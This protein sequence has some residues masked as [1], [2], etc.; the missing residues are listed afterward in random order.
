MTQPTDAETRMAEEEWAKFWF[1]NGGGI[2][3]AFKYRKWTDLRDLAM[4]LPK[5]A[6]QAGLAAGKRIGR[7]EAIEE[8]AKVAGEYFPSGIAAGILE[9]IRALKEPKF[10]SVEITDEAIA[11]FAEKM[12]DIVQTPIGRG[13]K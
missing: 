3:T 10:G 7:D 1:I 6:W 5:L 13:E 4:Q 12:K 2:H 9:E 8:C 11:D